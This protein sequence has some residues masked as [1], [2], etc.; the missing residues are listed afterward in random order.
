MNI[1]DA[2][3]RFKIGDV[4]FVTESST[5]GCYC[6]R[7]IRIETMGVNEDGAFY[8][9]KNLSGRDILYPGNTVYPTEDEAKHAFFD[10][11]LKEMEKNIADIKE[12]LGILTKQIG[13]SVKDEQN[14]AN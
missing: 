12:S 13:E 3:F 9:T 8:G 14:K 4:A 11:R 7:R 2:N 10:R 6:I 5:S 1:Y